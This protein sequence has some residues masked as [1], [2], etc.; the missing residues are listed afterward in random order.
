VILKIV[1]N[2]SFFLVSGLIGAV[3]YASIMGPILLAF[4]VAKE[5]EERNT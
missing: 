3:V 1:F 4:R 5:K 2:P